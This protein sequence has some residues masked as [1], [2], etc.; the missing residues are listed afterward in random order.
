MTLAEMIAT[1]HKIERAQQDRTEVW[2]VVV[3]ETGKE[4]GR[5]YRGSFQQP[6]G[7]PQ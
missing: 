2:R 7:E 5:M 4:I 6:Q 3:D 1:L